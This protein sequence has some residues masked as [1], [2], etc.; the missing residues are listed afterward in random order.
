MRVDLFDFE[1]PPERIALRPAR[2]RDAARMLVAEGESPFR[3]L[4]VRDLPRML[5]RGDVLVFNDTKVIPAQLE[6]R[7]G[8]GENRRHAAQAAGSQALADIRP[9]RQAAPRRRHDRLCKRRFRDRRGTPRGRQLD[10]RFCGERPGRGAARPR[11]P[12]AA[13][14]LYRRQA[15]HRRGRRDRL[16]DHVRR[17]RRR[18][19]RP[20]RRAPLHARADRRAGCGGG[21]TRDAHAACR[22]GHLPAGQGRGHR[23]PRDA[24]R[25]GRDRP[26]HR[27]AAQRRAQGGWAADRGRHHL[28]PPARKRGRRGRHDPRFRRR[29][30]DLHH[31][32]LSLQGGGRADD[33]L[34]S[35]EIDAVHAGFGADGARADAGAYAY[36]IGEGYRFYSYGDSS[37]LLPNSSPAAT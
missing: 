9:Q 12:D 35:A 33:Q 26:G 20:H 23:R 19:R 17:K 6:G 10:A 24:R 15:P 11:G 8:G 36:A 29:H 30:R 31:A 34:P 4:T 32:G 22:G 37:L 2:P 21:E 28:A 14:A 18:G 25:M 1:L 16:P 27:H 5:R 7:R 13:P 3:D